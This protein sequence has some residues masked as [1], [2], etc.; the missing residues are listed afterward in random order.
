MKIYLAGFIQ[1]SKIQECIG[2]RKQIRDYY[3]IHDWPIIFLDPLNGKEVNTISSDGL[4]SS[5]P[6]NAI[7]H[8]D[9]KCVMDCDIVIV[10]MDTFG[11]TRPLTGTI[12]E[13]AWAWEHHKPIIMITDDSK[14]C[15]HPFLKNFASMIF[16]TVEKMIE[17]KAVNYMFKGTVSADY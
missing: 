11:E 12:C 7:L 15:N 4:K 1:G 17:E 5:I 13:L 16:P 9:F 3:K 8:R 2:W 10:N 14:Y 6:P